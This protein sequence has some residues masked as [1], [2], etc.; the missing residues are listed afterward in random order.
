MENQSRNVPFKYHQDLSFS[1]P[2]YTVLG[3]PNKHPCTEVL[4]VTVPSFLKSETHT[5]WHHAKVFLGR[6]LPTHT[7]PQLKKRALS[8]LCSY[9][10]QR[11]PT[12]LLCKI[13]VT[14][15]HIA[16]LILEVSMSEVAL[17]YSAVILGN[18]GICPELYIWLCWEGCAYCISE[19]I[20]SYCVL[21]QVYI[22]YFIN[23]TRSS[24]LNVCQPYLSEVLSKQQPC[25]I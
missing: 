15:L 22:F 8:A 17:W 11:P 1:P 10:E 5:L 7:S 18:S 21:V 14:G 16:L 13:T 3:P 23:E 6:W 9:D 24:W 25:D 4:I 20:W 19:P 2:L 12:Q